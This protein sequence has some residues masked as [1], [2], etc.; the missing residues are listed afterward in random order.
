MFLTL[1]YSICLNYSIIC[2]VKNAENYFT[3]KKCKFIA[4]LLNI[5]YT[6]YTSVRSG[7]FEGR[8]NGE[9]EEEKQGKKEENF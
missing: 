6:N 2:L 1:D 5:C 7:Y 9:K 4:F 3:Q 8:T